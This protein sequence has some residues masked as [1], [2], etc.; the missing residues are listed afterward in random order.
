MAS[1]SGIC[2]QRTLDFIDRLRRRDRYDDACRDIVEELAWHG[3]SHVTVWSMP[4]ANENPADC[5]LLNTRPPEYIARYVEMNHVMRDPVVTELRRTLTPFSW[6]DVR[7]RRDL[8]KAEKAIIDEG[9]AFGAHDGM[10]V[11]IVTPSGSVAV[12][13]PCGTAPDLSPHARAAVEIIG[14]VGYAALRTVLGKPQ[15]PAAARTPLSARER[16]ILQYVAAGKSDDEIGDLLSLS[17]RTVT[18]HVE[19]AK[20]KL[21][22]LRRPQAVVQALRNG[23]IDL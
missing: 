10:T 20:R 4:R 5:M 23:E 8:S 22:A 3:Y 17:T 11:P 2:A 1:A 18:W 6:S 7:A 13:S 19:N 14:M 15:A 9:R 12:F 21:D 16:E